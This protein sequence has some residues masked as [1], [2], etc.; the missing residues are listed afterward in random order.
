M[1]VHSSHSARLAATCSSTARTLVAGAARGS[2]AVRRGTVEQMADS[3]SSYRRKRDFHAS[4]EPS[5][6]GPA[7]DADAPRFVVQEHHARRLH[8]DLRLERDGV[9]ASWAIPNGIPEDPRHNRKAVHV[10]GHPLDYIDF[11]GTIPS[12]YGAGE[13]MIWDSGTYICEKWLPNRVIVVFDGE[14]LNGRYALFHAG[15]SEQDWMIHRM[16]PPQDA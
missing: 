13:V 3:L 6:D 4:P 15:R 7:P 16:D 14:K 2:R 8:W 10:E 12:G 9:L 5:G 11:H 1:P